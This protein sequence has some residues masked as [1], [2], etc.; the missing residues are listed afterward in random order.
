MVSPTIPLFLWTALSPC[1]SAQLSSIL[2][3]LSLTPVPSSLVTEV[4]P[5][6]SS[7]AS[8]SVS[9]NASTTAL[10]SST[11]KDVIGITGV[12]PTAS[13]NATTTTSATARSRPTQNTTPCN[14]HPE[15][16]SRR[17]S[18]V[19]MVVAHNSP[20][21]VPH[22][23]ASNQVL[24]VVTQLNDGIRGLQFETQKPNS[25]SPIRLCHT[26][27]NLLDVGTLEAYLTTVK[28]WLEDNPYEVIAI[29]MGNNNGQ[30][31]K[32]PATDYIEPFQN[33]G[34]LDYVWTPS[35]MSLNLTEWPTLQEMILKNERVV[36]MIDYNADQDAVPWLLSEFD[37][38][39][40]TPFSPTDPA[41]PCT[42]QRPPNQAE[43]VS[44]NRMYMVNHNL[45]ID[46]N[47]AGT[48]ILV[49]AYGQLEEINAVSGN[50]SLGLNVQGC[51]QMWNRPPNWL[52]VDYYN[53]G[54]FNGSVFQV[55]ATANNVSYNRDSCC[56]VLRKESSSSVL[57]IDGSWLF[58]AVGIAVA[59][60]IR[61]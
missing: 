37:Y 22:N 1:V 48:S 51:E 9:R 36:V 40:Q 2:S 58:A 27:C 52:L 14:G 32:N 35:A 13:G 56:G 44:R 3:S 31:T 18:N 55:A 57:S 50:A 60:V 10:H 53:F 28:Q 12:A 30:D 49:P 46:I 34:M 16:C 21:V 20:F 7:F 45:N 41:F 4:T 25:S 19:S 26:S 43:D 59:A 23:A 29:M 5:E 15:F 38:Q 24:G 61:M 39:W 6:S 42:Q 33:S 47:I 11:T 8:L 17:F 54:N